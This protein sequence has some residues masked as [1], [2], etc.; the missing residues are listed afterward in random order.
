MITKQVR[1]DYIMSAGRTLSAKLQA[2]YVTL[3][4]I[5]P[6]S[7][8]SHTLSH[9]RLHLTFL[10][11]SSPKLPHSLHA[12]KHQL[13]ASRA[14]EWLRCQGA[15][16]LRLAKSKSPDMMD[17]AQPNGIGFWKCSWGA[18]PPC[19]SM[20]GCIPGGPGIPPQLPG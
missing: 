5:C 4:Q 11:I 12:E 7:C 1:H 17:T 16:S 8:L 14:S 3:V 20:S 19:Q 15:H 10:E 18:M 6:L 9:L 2:L 13:M